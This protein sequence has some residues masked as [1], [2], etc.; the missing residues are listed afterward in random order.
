[1]APSVLAATRRRAGGERPR[2]VD[3]QALAPDPGET[4]PIIRK[5]DFSAVRQDA[6]KAPPGRLF[7]SAIRPARVDTAISAGE[8]EPMFK[9][10][11]G[12]A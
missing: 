10:S 3:G 12:A 11:C 6:E 4:L 2:D 8:R 1:M 5:F 7:R 9:P